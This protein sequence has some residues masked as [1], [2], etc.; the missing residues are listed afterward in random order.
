M[1]K[2]NI[3]KSYYEP[4]MGKDLPDYKVLGWESIESQRLRFDV[5]ISNVNLDGKRILDVGCGLGNLSEYISEKGIKVDYTG[6]DILEKMIQCAKKKDLEAEF[7]CMDIFN[8]HPFKK[9]QFDV[10]YASGTFNLNL[11]NNMEFLKNALIK[12]FELSHNAVAF[13]LLHD[14]SPD[15]E[16]QY[17]YYKPDIVVELIKEMPYRI[18]EVNIIEQYLKNDFTVVCHK[19]G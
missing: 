1:H 19:A 12:F 10:V 8:A 3:I 4:N 9:G 17:Y 16:G 5:L 14:M 15:K 13:N 11:G 7:Y 18:D 2:L 6:V